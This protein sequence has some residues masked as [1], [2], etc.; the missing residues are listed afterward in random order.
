MPFYI[1]V[2]DGKRTGFELGAKTCGANI[3]MLQQ[4]EDGD[5]YKTFQGNFLSSE[6]IQERGVPLP[7]LEGVLSFLRGGIR[8]SA[9]QKMPHCCMQSLSR[10]RTQTNLCQEI[11]M[12]MSKEA[13][14]C[15]LQATPN[16]AMAAAEN[17]YRYNLDDSTLPKLVKNHIIQCKQDK[18][19]LRMWDAEGRFLQL[20][21][22]PPYTVLDLL[23]Q[24]YLIL[25]DGQRYGYWLK[26]HQDTTVTEP[27]NPELVAAKTQLAT[28]EAKLAMI[29]FPYTGS[30]GEKYIAVPSC[31]YED[32]MQKLKLGTAVP[33]NDPYFYRLAVQLQSAYRQASAGKGV[34][35]HAGKDAEGRVNQAF[36]DQRIVAN[37]KIHGMGSPCGQVTKKIAEGC[38]MVRRGEVNRGL[39]EFHGAINYIAALCIAVED[40]VKN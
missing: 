9:F 39:V 13:S 16:E 31:L 40:G 28:L 20:A 1:M 19:M 25:I 6:A 35:R 32:F 36:H 26:E 29:D 21:I 4:G 8:E 30:E 34:E 15:T 24:G 3:I 27:N 14:L 33:L 10:Y 22:L 12:S 18:E 38:D 5:I 37:A 23:K 7:D 11:S 17:V 2:V